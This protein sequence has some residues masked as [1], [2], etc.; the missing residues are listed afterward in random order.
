MRKA[1]LACLL[2]AACGTR[3]GATDLALDYRQ[4][5]VLLNEGDYEG[6]LELARLGSG[7]AHREKSRDWATAFEVLRGESL[8]GL[9]KPE[10]AAAALG[11]IDVPGSRP[12]LQARRN[13]TL[14]MELC[15]LASDEQAASAAREFSRADT[16]LEEAAR[17]A[18][19]ADP[20]VQAEVEIRR[21]S[22]FIDKGQPDAARDT[23]RHL[24]DFARL[25]RLGFFE[26]SALVGLAYISGNRG[27]FEGCADYSK[28]SLSTARKI[29]SDLYI[30]KSLGNLVWC[31]FNVGDYDAALEYSKQA[32]T[33]APKRHFRNEVR[34]LFL[35]TGNIYY[36][37][38]DFP[39]AVDYYRRALKLAQELRRKRSIALITANLGHAAFAQND[40]AAAEGFN[41][42]AL[43]L[44]RELGDKASILRSELLRARIL[45]KK[46]DAPASEAEFLR[47]T[48]D[49]SP[50]DVQWGAHS[51]LATI[52]WSRNR[53]Q[54]A[55]RE[56]RS[57][58]AIV[59][60]SRDALLADETK[61]TFLS[62]LSELYDSY[63]RF[64]A[65][66]GRSRDALAVADRSHAM[67]LAR[68][69]EQS[70]PQPSGASRDTQPV[71]RAMHAVLLSY[72][73]A[74]GGSYLWVSTG[75][76]VE[77]FPL[78]PQQEIENQVEAYQKIVERPRDALRDAE[79]Q[80]VALWRMLIEPAQKL[81]PQGS[82]VIIVPDRGL[83]R[84]AFET[85]IVP[86]PIPHFWIEDVTV[87][88][89]PSLGFLAPVRPRG[90]RDSIL[91]IGDPTQADQAFPPLANAGAELAGISN[92]YPTADRV[93]FTGT[94]ATPAA[95]L[96]A[97]PGQYRLIHFAAHASANHISPLDSAVILARSGD[98]HRLYARQV[99]SIPLHA[100]LVTISACRSAGAKAYAGEGLVGF[101]W[102]FLAAGAR[103]VTAGLWEVDD[104]ST[105]Q[106]MLQLHRELRLGRTPAEA[107]RSSKLALLRSGTAYRRPF[108]WA[109]FLL[110]TRGN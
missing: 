42:E 83:H 31:Y 62:S 92:L 50:S 32:E 104:A 90:E 41:E 17:A 13:A 67:T 38:K 6:T 24:L 35:N 70:D 99:V 37:L 51:G 25:H 30:V 68:R 57:A 96:E 5:R 19:R 73:L 106:L 8:V 1:A 22:C 110:Y 18:G 49:A 44:K 45:W 64:L 52:Y 14:A 16:L 54:Q 59:E 81:I 55:E 61:I 47:L 21:A 53:N 15:S 63:I 94:S 77:Q 12:D 78:P 89:A 23:Y 100:E 86:A 39:S 98:D 48:A 69:A 103:N 3:R 9:D 11:A 29:G 79:N 80:G 75:S 10:V 85:L 43:R 93:V 109:P 65:G 33:V 4:A 28:E 76:R 97:N 66:S 107:L 101:A 71:A 36:A 95:Y 82:N 72:W 91:L 84:L 26:G 74:P 105:A 7:K 108:Y 87:A 20:E 2:L 60:T 46:G 27:Y 58:L 102:A 88:E 56:F 34:T 40:I